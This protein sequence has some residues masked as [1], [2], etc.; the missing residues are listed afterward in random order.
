MVSGRGKGGSGRSGR[1]VE[2]VL[3]GIRKAHASLTRDVIDLPGVSGT[4]VGMSGG[5]PCLTVHVEKLGSG[6][7]RKIPD[8]VG[9]FR[10]VVEESGRLKRQD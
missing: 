7:V 8:T 5:K 1:S 3:D 6:V 10:V 4:S 2:G 9:G